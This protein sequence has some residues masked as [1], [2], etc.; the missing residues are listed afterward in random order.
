MMLQ[1][2]LAILFTYLV[3]DSYIV[4]RMLDEPN[5]HYTF[6]KS[7]D[8][9]RTLAAI[10]FTCAGLGILW[11]VWTSETFSWLMNIP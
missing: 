9:L 11:L 7:A 4:L 3:I 1:G 5:V 2:G 8:T 10:E 6:E